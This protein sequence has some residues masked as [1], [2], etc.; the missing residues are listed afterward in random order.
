[1]LPQSAAALG[2]AVHITLAVALGVTLAY[3]WRA[4]RLN[5]MAATGPYPFML[6]ALAGV[7]AT[8]FFVILRS[9]ARLSSSWCRTR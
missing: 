1:M 4:V 8:N 6:A 5:K 3:T 2:I 9:S 7:W